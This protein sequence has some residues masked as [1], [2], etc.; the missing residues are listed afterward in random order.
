MAE[1]GEGFG[2]RNY[3]LPGGGPGSAVLVTGVGI[4]KTSTN[5]AAAERFVDYL[6]SADAQRYFAEQTFE[7]P[8]IDGIPSAALLP[9]LD[10]LSTPDIDVSDLG[11]LAA[12][13]DLLRKAGV[14][15]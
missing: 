9:P 8:L 10:G 5:R 1:E 15:P 3:F 6:L 14:L 12:T 11:D 7:Y 2:A 13:Q 4:L